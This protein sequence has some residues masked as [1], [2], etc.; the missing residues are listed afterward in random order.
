MSTPG[1]IAIGTWTRI[2]CNGCPSHVPFKKSSNH[3]ML[4]KKAFHYMFASQCER[5]R[6]IS[7]RRNIS[8]EKKMSR[9]ER[10]RVAAGERVLVI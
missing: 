3:F 2:G 9:R 10:E 1:H 4:R 6:Q 7:A 5:A 8:N